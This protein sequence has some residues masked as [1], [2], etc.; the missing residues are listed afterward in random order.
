VQANAVIESVRPWWDEDPGRGEVARDLRPLGAPSATIW[1]A[2]PGPQIKSFSAKGDRQLREGAAWWRQINTPEDRGGYGC[3]TVSMT[4][5]GRLPALKRHRLGDGLEILGTDD[6]LPLWAATAD[7]W[8]LR[9]QGKIRE[10]DPIRDCPGWLL[11]AF[12]AKW[13]AV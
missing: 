12:G 13:R 7:G 4:A 6:A 2:P 5:D 11:E 1:T 10:P 3:W 8:L 9:Q